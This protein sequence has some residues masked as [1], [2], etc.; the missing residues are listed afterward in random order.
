MLDISIV[1]PALNEASKIRRDIETAAAFFAENALAG[2]VI[3]VDD[4]STDGTSEAAWLAEAG[5]SVK[6][7]IL[8]LEKNSGKGKA[9][10]L[11]VLQSRGEIV[12]YADSGTCIP[13]ANALPVIGKIRQGTLDIGLA[14]RRLAETVIR[15]D[16]P[17]RRRI[18]SRLFR[19]A[20][21]WIDGLP[22]WISDSQCGFKVYRGNAARELFD[23]LTTS[24]FLFEIE[25]ILKAL[26][27]GL[28]VEEF[29]VEW[30][31]DIDT[32]L[33]PA[34]D[35]KRVLAELLRIR[36]LIKKE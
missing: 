8:R 7:L 28:R 19:R 17:F 16:Q 12:I 18:V 9:V 33:R 20:A 5:P 22:P 1:I 30:T 36:S 3:V 29:P 34:A 21:I 13:Y 26:R 24:G 23:G 14:S 2:E 15:K 6:R 31:C 35:A 32:R 25:I 4:G 11:G 10:Q 27:R